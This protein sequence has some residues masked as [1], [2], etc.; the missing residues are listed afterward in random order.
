MRHCAALSSRQIEFSAETLQVH[1][2]T[3]IC[4]QLT[5]VLRLDG[6]EAAAASGMAIA[7]LA[8]RITAHRLSSVP[9][10]VPAAG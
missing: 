5:S 6:I 2:M 4:R 8:G 9:A 3:R 1:P 7:Y 10:G